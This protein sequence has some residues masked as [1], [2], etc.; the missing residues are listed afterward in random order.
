MAPYSMERS[1]LFEF[2]AP[3]VCGTTAVQRDAVAS[4]IPILSF[5]SLL[6]QLRRSSS[7]FRCIG[8]RSPGLHYSCVLKS[9]VLRFRQDGRSFGR[10]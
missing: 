6:P 4:I 3:R 10:D 8:P 2:G 5:M 9:P 1:E 7:G